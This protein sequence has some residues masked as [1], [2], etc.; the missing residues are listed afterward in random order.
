MIDIL[1]PTYNREQDLVKNILYLNKLVENEG[2]QGK[3]RLIVSNNASIDN[4]EQELESI[5][6]KISLEIVVY[7]QNHNI[8]LEKNAVFT[9]ENATSDYV[10]F[11]GDDDYLPE[12]YLSKVVDIVNKNEIG[13]IIPR[14]VGLYSDGTIKDGRQDFNMREKQAGFMS[15][16]DLS[17][18]GHQ[19]SGLVF[20]REGVIENY[21]SDENNRNIYLF[22]FFITYGLL[23]YRSVY[24]PQFAVKVTQ[25]NSKDWN[26]DDSGLLT[27]IY[28]NYQSIFKNNR[29]KK[30][31]ASLNLTL[32]QRWRFR[33]GVNPIGSLKALRHILL[34]NID[35]DIKISLIV[36]YPLFYA[37]AVSRFIKNLIIRR[38]V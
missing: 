31:L 9:L 37:L 5:K 19:L 32:Q 30:I 10:M 13:V 16:L 11:L 2:L 6:S 3:F 14:F 15:V 33:F 29:I 12:G 23:R 1:I 25:S 22:I 8:G 27:E 34:S 24:L 18:Y 21:L 38:M 20:K 35:S 7:T 36:A 26:Y 28:K 4:T 17:E